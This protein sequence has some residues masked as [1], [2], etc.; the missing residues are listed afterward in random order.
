MSKHAK[1]NRRVIINPIA[2]AM[3]GSRLLPKEAREGLQKIITDSLAEYRAGRDCRAQWANMADAL[4]VAEA[5]SEIGICADET[6]RERIAAAQAAMSVAW[7][8]ATDKGT[9]A[10]RSTEYKALDEGLWMA[11]VQLDHCSRS[12]YE[13][14]TIVVRNRSR[15]ALAGNVAPGTIVL[16]DNTPKG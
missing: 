5:L 16:T 3:E 15:G 7:L 8:R 14:A 10:L 12:E 6:S 11:R 2:V 13:R 4:N 1:F 9:W